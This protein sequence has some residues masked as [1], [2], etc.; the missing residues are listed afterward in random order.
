MQLGYLMFLIAAIIFGIYNIILFKKKKVNNYIDQVI[1]YSNLL[2]VILAL[3]SLT[4]RVGFPNSVFLGIGSPFKLL[5]GPLFLYFVRSVVYKQNMFNISNYKLYFH[6]IPFILFF[7]CFVYL[8]NSVDLFGVY[9]KY[10]LTFLSIFSG[11][12]ILIYC[13]V[14]LLLMQ[15]Y[16]IVR[17]GKRER[18]L[19][20]DGLLILIFRGLFLIGDGLE[21]DFSYLGNDI[22]SLISYILLFV[23]ILSIHFVLIQ[24]YLIRP[25]REVIVQE[26]NKVLK[27][28]MNKSLVNKTQDSKYS[29]SRSD[30]QDLQAYSEKL[31]TLEIDFFLDKN[32]S[33]DKL[34]YKLH[35]S[36]HRLSQTFSLKLDTSY[37]T[38]VHQKRISYSVRLLIEKPT[39]SINEV[40]EE[41]GFNST[42]SF[43]RAFKDVKGMTPGQYIKDYGNNS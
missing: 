41:S 24:E 29:K 35:I 27:K 4:I 2:L 16:E 33:I 43:Y 26:D 3:Y 12:H 8:L 39:L 38:Y 15:N 18:R 5:Y 31:E 37:T 14:S 1:Y 13:I 40:S 23:I 7:I 28:V 32:L 6:F 17:A 19:Y 10:Y 25:A 42:A 34:A 30:L 9:S 20:F 11:A 36:P 22:G 21:G